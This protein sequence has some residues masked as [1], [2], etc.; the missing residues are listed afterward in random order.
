MKIAN[1]IVTAL[2][3]VAVFP[4]LLTQTFV[5]LVMSIN[6]KSMAYMALNLLLGKDNQITGNHLGFEETIIDLFNLITGKTE[7]ATS[8]DLKEL[9]ANL[10]EEFIPIK[11]LLIASMVFIALGVLVA[12]VIIGCS[13]FTKAYKTITALGLGGAF[14]FLMSLILFGRAAKPLVE[15]TVDVASLLSGSLFDSESIVGSLVNGILPGA[16]KV[17]SF[18]MGGAV[19]GALIIML[20]VAIWEFSYIVTLP[21]EEKLKKKK[22]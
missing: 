6:E 14:C 2:L 17:D 12:I 13:I 3:A 20:G 7:T 11:N 21:K 16:I 22:A 1:R 9:L 10:P 5:T 8:I 18:T 4:V 15:G 19:F